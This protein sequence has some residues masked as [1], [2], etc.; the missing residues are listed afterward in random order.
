MERR[1]FFRN[2]AALGVI[3]ASPKILQEIQ[4]TEGD[5]IQ[6]IKEVKPDLIE[7]KHP[8]GIEVDGDFCLYNQDG[9]FICNLQ[10]PVVSS[11]YKRIQIPNDFGM[12]EYTM[13]R[14]S[15]QLVGIISAYHGK[16]IIMK[17]EPVSCKCV[18][19]KNTLIYFDAYMS[20][21]AHEISTDGFFVRATFQISGAITIEEIS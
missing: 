4:S 12:M 10:S 6:V 16:E 2:L 18:Y 1:S 5:V 3:A 7:P 20:E 11:D 9:E 8:L 19:Q 15:H 21:Y 13:G 17:D 14:Q